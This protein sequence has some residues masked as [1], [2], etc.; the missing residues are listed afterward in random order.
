MRVALTIPNN[1]RVT[2]L[3]QPW[4]DEVGGAEI[5]EIARLADRLGFARLTVGE[6]FLIPADHVAVSGAHRLQATT[7][8][9]YLTRQAL[10]ALRW[11]SVRARA[12]TS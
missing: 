5:G 9:A 8:L 3:R 11:H 10:P 7:A 12:T 1:H 2:A 6:H 4:Q